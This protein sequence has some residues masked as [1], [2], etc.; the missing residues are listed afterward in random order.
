M[1]ATFTDATG[2]ERIIELNAL[3]LL[4][5][6]EQFGF[7]LYYGKIPDTLPQAFQIIGYLIAPDIP[8]E[9]QAALF[10]TVPAAQSALEAFIEAT[11]P[12]LEHPT[13]RIE[14]IT[15][16]PHT[17]T[18]KHGKEYTLTLDGLAI[19][20]ILEKL[21]VDLLSLEDLA[22]ACLK[23]GTL[24]RMLHLLSDSDEPLEDFSRNLNA[25]NLIQAQA[26]FQNELLAFLPSAQAEVLRAAADLVQERSA[27]LLSFVRSTLQNA[28]GVTA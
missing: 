1:P 19:E 16:M 24:V 13:P 26:A 7:D 17:F 27:E 14:E 8:E 6:Q 4:T 22:A 11:S 20:T 25:D 9:E 2:T 18:N 21:G 3:Q 15:Y 28:K 23:V 5:I 10:A 12:R